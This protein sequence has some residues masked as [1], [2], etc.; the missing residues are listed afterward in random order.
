MNGLSF[1][2]VFL[3]GGVVMWPLLL[4]SVAGLAVIMDR[5]VY[6]LRLAAGRPGAR[7]QAVLAAV[8]EGRMEEAR[9]DLAVWKHP[10][11]VV[12]RVWLENAGRPAALR[13]DL[14]KT[15]GARQLGLVEKRLRLLGALAHLAPL[16]GLL[17]TVMGMVMA[18]AQLENL[19][20]TPRPTDLAGGIWTALL[21]TVA[22][23]VV[24]IP[25]MAAYHG[26]E[27][28]ADQVARQMEAAVVGLEDA[29]GQPGPGHRAGLEMARDRELPDRDMVL[30]QG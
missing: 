5:A 22:G 2:E 20:G 25:C 19:V 16:L 4:C 15:E 18:F 7:Q 10:V 12:M 23:L 21:T 6:F 17:G 28:L 14:V 1:F 26:F 13:A 3:R 11:G 27:G 24:A 30:V 29:S 9:R 8:R